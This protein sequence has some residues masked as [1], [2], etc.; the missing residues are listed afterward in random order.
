MKNNRQ[1]REITREDFDS[2]FMW[3]VFWKIIRQETPINFLLKVL[4]V[5]TGFITLILF[6][7]LIGTFLGN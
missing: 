1:R 3:K 4:L 7:V 2:M 5:A 6:I